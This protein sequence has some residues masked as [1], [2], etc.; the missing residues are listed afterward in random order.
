MTFIWK[1]EKM[2]PNSTPLPK[3]VTIMAEH[4]KTSRVSLHHHSTARATSPPPLPLI[5]LDR[6]RKLTMK[7]NA[8]GNIE[9]LG[10][11]SLRSKSSSNSRFVI[12]IIFL[13]YFKESNCDWKKL[14]SRN[15]LVS[16]RRGCVLRTGILY[17]RIL[18]SEPSFNFYRCSKEWI[19]VFLF[20]QYLSFSV[21]TSQKCAK[22]V[23]EEWL[24]SCLPRLELELLSSATQSLVHSY[25]GW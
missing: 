21:R 9:P 15:L 3:S 7:R 18:G 19:E 4:R 13:K 25:S 24:N 2:W 20:F 22:I 11:S 1:L 14:F 5:K 17:L 8:A 6:P 12:E 16:L 23:A 10:R